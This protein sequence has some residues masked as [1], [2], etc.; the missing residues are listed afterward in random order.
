MRFDDDDDP[1]AA[2][3]EADNYAKNILQSLRDKTGDDAKALNTFIRWLIPR[4]QAFWGNFQADG[5][6]SYKDFRRFVHWEQKWDGRVQHVF[7]ILDEEGAGYINAKHC[8]HAKRWF[9]HGSDKADVDIKD[10]RRTFEMY[11]GS[12]GLA[13][14]IILDP[15]DYG[16]CAFVVF[17]K[18]CHKIGIRRNMNAI[19][20]ELTC[21]C[22]ERHLRYRDFDPVGE[23]LITH[24]ATSLAI[25]AQGTLREGWDRMCQVSGEKGKLKLKQFISYCSLLKID[26]VSARSMFAIFDPHRRE[27]NR[28]LA[29]YD[30][31]KFLYQFD[32]GN[33]DSLYLERYSTLKQID[34]AAYDDNKDHGKEDVFKDYR[35]PDDRHPLMVIKRDP[36]EILLVL[37]PA[38]HDEYQRRRANRMNIFGGV[39]VKQTKVDIRRGWTD[40]DRIKKD[41]EVTN[42][43]WDKLMEDVEDDFGADKKTPGMRTP[44]SAAPTPMR[45]SAAQ[46]PM[47]RGQAWPQ[48]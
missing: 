44:S 7:S 3:Q 30:S 45:S 4:W 46:T 38:E 48:R 40:L 34:L 11:Y 36:Y 18:A 16:T 35:P 10:C 32:P 29:E 13:W 8:C 37:S 9:F 23:R 22:T 27:A 47:A 28:E 2:E 19:W 31:L 1:A 14:R 43:L 26:K 15:E 12:L 20:S 21:G 41:Y 25:R 39:A 33:V 24:F 5:T 42:V 6:M 17:I